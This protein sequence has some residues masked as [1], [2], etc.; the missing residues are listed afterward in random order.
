MPHHPEHDHDSDIDTANPW[1]V[2]PYFAGDEGAPGQRPI[3]NVSPPVVSWLCPSIKVEGVNY[4]ATPGSY[5]PDE[6]LKITVKVDNRGVPNALVTVSLYWADPT[7]SFVIP[8]FITSTMF[9]VVGRSVA[10]PTE[11]PPMFWTPQSSKIPPHF[12]LLA[13]ASAF[14][15]EAAPGS[16]TPDPLNDRHWAQYNLQSVTLPASN[17][18]NAVFWAAN[19]ETEAAAFRVTVRPVAEAG[20]KTLAQVLKAEPIA[21]KHEQLTLYRVADEAGERGPQDPSLILELKRGE[22]QALGIAAQSPTLA[23]HQFTALEVIQT[24]LGSEKDEAAMTGSLGIVVFAKETK[25]GC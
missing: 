13:H 18:V 4:I 10:G 24:R 19:P 6:P 14:P 22:R 25:P 15:P 3:T 20:L 2:I 23:P 12:C 17:K 5:R 8:T 1:I 16:S 11:M 9:P 7:T 21:L